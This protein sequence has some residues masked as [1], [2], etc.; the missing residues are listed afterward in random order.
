MEEQFQG[1]S[2]TEGGVKDSQQGKTVC[3]DEFSNL[4]ELNVDSERQNPITDKGVVDSELVYGALKIIQRQELVLD[5]NVKGHTE[6]TS[7]CVK[8]KTLQ[9]LSLRRLVL[10]WT[11][12]VHRGPQGGTRVSWCTQMF[13]GF[14][15]HVWFKE[16]YN[17]NVKPGDLVRSLR[18]CTRLQNLRFDEYVL[19]PEDITSL[20]ETLT[21]LPSL[22]E[23]Q[24]YG[25][26]GD[27]S[28]EMLSLCDSLI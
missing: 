23:L 13:L 2:L 19:D 10:G 14:L 16:G 5:R 1:L 7:G 9:D 21:C 17:D 20:A 4:R 26:Y 3:D 25:P 6:V 15:S 8:P 24:L 22:K 12:D 27:F 28:S 11:Q 18:L